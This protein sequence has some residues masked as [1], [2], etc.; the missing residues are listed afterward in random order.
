[1]ENKVLKQKRKAAGMTQLEVAQKGGITDIGYLNYEQGKREP[2]IGTAIKIA[3]VLGVKDLRE[4][5]R[6]TAKTL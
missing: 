3:D 4:L 1:M 6:D 5:W 2:K